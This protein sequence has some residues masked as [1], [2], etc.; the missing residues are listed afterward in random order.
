MKVCP[1]CQS[2]QIQLYGFS[3]NVACLNDL[4]R[5]RFRCREC[6][7]IFGANFHNLNFNQR[8]S[9]KALNSKIFNFFIH[10][11]SNRQVAR[12]ID[13]S[14]ECVRRR[15][16]RMAQRALSFHCE[17]MRTTKISE[18]IC[19]DGLEN[20]AFSQYDPNHINHA[21][22]RDSLFIY[23]FDFAPLNRK[24]R[25]SI[26]QKERLRQIEQEFGR[27]DPGAIRKNTVKVLERLH[28]KSARS[29]LEILSDEHFQ[30]KRAVNILRKLEI[31]QTTI[32]SKACRNFQNILFSV[33]HSDLLVRQQLAVFARETISFAKTAGRMCQKYALFMVYKN[34]MAP[35]FRK[36][37]VRRPSA[38]VKSPAM[39]LGLCEN[40]MR[41]KEVFGRRSLER[42]KLQIPL[43]W[44]HFYDGTVPRECERSKKHK[45]RAA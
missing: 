17:M 24:G 41:F 37:H 26:W 19:F 31:D 11:M 9:D 45:K 38:H 13:V 35:Q 36:K 2:H 32:S 28:A 30:Y 33:N 22:G 20:F 6:R 25:M 14:E 4:R 27:Y 21:I 29:K 5:Q 8:H 43:E 34:Y 12:L 15:L 10:G 44:Q 42:D 40:V 23:D 3:N 18:A 1:H 16:A 39:E 7:K